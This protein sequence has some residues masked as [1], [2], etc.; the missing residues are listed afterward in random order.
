MG[1]AGGKRVWEVASSMMRRTRGLVKSVERMKRNAGV[2][3]ARKNGLQMD[4]LGELFRRGRNLE[5]RFIIIK[6]NLLEGNNDNM[7]SIMSLL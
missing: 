7:L 2:R 5:L 3:R 4:M 6:K 1:T